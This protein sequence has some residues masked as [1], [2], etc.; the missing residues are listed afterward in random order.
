MLKLAELA[1]ERG[2][3]S[4]A[5][6]MLAQLE[7]QHAPLKVLRAEATLAVRRGHRSEAERLYARVAEA[8]RD[9]TDALREL[10]SFAR[11]E[12]ASQKALE[13][14]DRIARARPDVL[15]CA[16]DR[17]ELLESIGKA[18]RR[19]R[20]ALKVALEVS[21]DETRLL[22]RDGRLLHRLGRDDEAFGQL[23]RALELK[24]QNP[25]LRAYLLALQPK[26][27]SS[28]LARAWSVDVPRV[29]EEDG[30]RQ[31]AADREGPRAGAARLVGDASAPQR[32][33]GDV[34]A[35]RRADSR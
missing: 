4:R 35:A 8:E 21:P 9:D 31:L 11:A 24:P 10:F 30:G 20:P 29:N 17:A 26:E 1:S 34:P 28:D 32:P 7:A 27:R 6:T 14:V 2:V 33:V 13:L 25:E 5:A 15:Q 16:L 22:E 12:G 19:A 23:K 3:P 18:R